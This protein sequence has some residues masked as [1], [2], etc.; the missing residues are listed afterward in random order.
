VMGFNRISIS[1]I[2]MLAPLVLA[3]TACGNGFQVHE[4]LK[5]EGD[6]LRTGAFNKDQKPFTSF[7]ATP[8]FEALK[9][10]VPETL[11][12]KT[13]AASIEKA[14]LQSKVS[15]YSQ[16][17]MLEVSLKWVGTGEPQI[18]RGSLAQNSDGIYGAKLTTKS[19]LKQ[20][21]FLD[22]T[23]TDL[24]CEVVQTKIRSEQNNEILG[25]VMFHNEDRILQ[26]GESTA[27]PEKMGAK[28][29]EF[30]I[31]HKEGKPVKV[32]AFVIV[33]GI[34]RYEVT[35][36]QKVGDKMV[37]K[38]LLK[39]DLVSPEGDKIDLDLSESPLKELG[40]TDLVGNDEDTGELIFLQDDSEDETPSAKTSTP[41]STKPAPLA[42]TKPPRATFVV[43]L[44]PKAPVKPETAPKTAPTPP[45]PIDVRAGL[46]KGA[47]T[48]ALPMSNQNTAE[49]NAAIQSLLKDCNSG[50]QTK[51]GGET[52]SQFFAKF[53][54]T[55][56]N[57]RSRD[58]TNT[59][60][61]HRDSLLGPASNPESDAFGFQL[62]TS[63][64]KSKNVPVVL[65]AA[66]TAIETGF[67]KLLRGG[68]GECGV[69]QFM[70][71]T[72]KYV[73]LSR[74]FGQAP[75]TGQKGERA[76]CYAQDDR[77]VFT[78]S[79]PAFA[80]YIK[81][82][83]DNYFPNNALMITASYNGGQGTTTKSESLVN[84]R[85]KN[86]RGLRA[87]SPQEIRLMSQDFFWHKARGSLSRGIISHTGQVAA[88]AQVL[89]NTQV[90]D[91]KVRVY[92][93]MKAE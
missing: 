75:K 18:F 79:M 81:F 93:S 72:A 70:P 83:N 73:G 33:N 76:L 13:F 48:L 90:Y 45:E 56:Q 69:M 32:R 25:G 61:V 63:E 12:S 11:E 71:G 15:D 91:E 8:S 66:M 49:V 20:N 65:A 41:D 2:L 4:G 77:V 28:A 59:L 64:M 9:A 24:S 50:D 46:G 88:A 74:L 6:N 35:E 52:R 19:G 89:L 82:L 22:A 10:E 55:V 5:L 30:Y 36:A 40:S 17:A 67:S 47:C 38:T 62:M 43:T 39:G 1:R 58:L 86:D 78:K 57:G 14:E 92:P 7:S 27:A 16:E 85:L 53:R 21:V 87:L 37:D 34:A 51:Y 26:T 31:S 54:Q 42:P 23:C 80:K 3:F 60:K 44:K 29:R 84:S 68:L